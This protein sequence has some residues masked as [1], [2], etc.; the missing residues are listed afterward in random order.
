[1]PLTNFSRLAYAALTRDV[2]WPLL[3]VVVAAAETGEI[4]YASQSLAD[5][6]GYDAVGLVGRPVEDLIPGALRAPHA[7]WRQDAGKTPRT[8]LMGAGRPLHGLRADGTVFPCHVGLNITEIAGVLVGTALVID[9]TSAAL[10]EGP[11]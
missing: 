1:M 8:R 6:F 10:Q 4:V 11:A 5:I 2:V 7:A 3:P 9:L